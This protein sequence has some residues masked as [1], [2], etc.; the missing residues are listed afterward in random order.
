MGRI[1]PAG[2]PVSGRRI[3]RK[4]SGFFTRVAGVAVT[5][6]LGVTRAHSPTLFPASRVPLSERVFGASAI[7]ELASPK[8]F[9]VRYL[10]L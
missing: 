7:A 9:P 3:D 10:Q 1:L 8:L 4:K 6:E 2:A 5:A